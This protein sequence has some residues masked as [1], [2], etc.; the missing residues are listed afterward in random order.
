MKE[1][2]DSQDGRQV[3]TLKNYPSSEFHRF[4]S[5][6]SLGRRRVS[7]R[8]LLRPFSSSSRFLIRGASQ[9]RAGNKGNNGSRAAKYPTPSMEMLFPV[10]KAK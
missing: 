1:R 3:I 9:A 4:A 2:T 7:P 10:V 6:R 8:P 5:T